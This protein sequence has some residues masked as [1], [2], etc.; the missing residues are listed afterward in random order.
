MRGKPA[1]AEDDVGVDPEV[2][3]V[4]DRKGGWLPERAEGQGHA[5]RTSKGQG[6][7][8]DGADGEGPG[9]VATRPGGAEGGGQRP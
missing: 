5:E 3:A 2:V 8:P 4:E 6:H 7:A 9:G 1:V